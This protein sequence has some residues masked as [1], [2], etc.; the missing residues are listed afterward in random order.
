M[1]NFSNFVMLAPKHLRFAYGTV[2]LTYFGLRLT[3]AIV[4][5]QGIMQMP[6]YAADAAMVGAIFLGALVGIRMYLHK[7]TDPASD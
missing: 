5:R 1:V 4:E 2:A 3:M 6:P 7:D